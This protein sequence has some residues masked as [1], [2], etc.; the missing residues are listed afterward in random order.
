MIFGS[1]PGP[2]KV[3]L[4]I[5]VLNQVGAFAFA[6]L[7]VL[8][9]PHLVTAALT[10]FGVA[11]LVSRW[12]GGVLLDRAAPRTLI[13]L[14]LTA[15]GLALLALAVARTP[16]QV[17]T[18][19]AVTG[20][21]FEIYEPATSELLA[22]V[23]EGEWRQ[24]AYAL[25]GT[26]L[27]AA[28]A[29][30]GLLAAVLL[31]YGVRWLL[32]ADAA[33]CL[34][35]AMVALTRLPPGAA[36][37]RRTGRWRPPRRLVRLTAGATAYAFGYLA[38]LMFTPFVLLQRGAPAWLPGLTLAAAA[39]LAPVT[40]KPLSGHPRVALLASGA[41]ALTM[42]VTTNVPLTVAAYVAWAMAGNALLG[43]WPALAADAAPEP[44]RPR[45]FAFLGL[46]WGVAQ[47]AVPA[48]VGTVA[49]VTGWT[50]AAS[51][52]AAIAF[53]AAIGSGGAR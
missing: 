46:S 52:A 6:F 30:S 18:A 16:W 7:A 4:G 17:L 48:V 35:A 20:L 36:P 22:R 12:A 11:T 44:D 5:R 15:T 49:T 8:A 2:A 23:T 45:W 41:F 10:V 38:I 33:T 29:I 13:V 31:P 53:V 27:A 40:R 32:V 42:A 1:L 25:L 50:A 14:G 9:G 21:A 39:L 37:A 19:I 28:G 51:L 24:D 3:L 43:H 34:A 26:S 47:P